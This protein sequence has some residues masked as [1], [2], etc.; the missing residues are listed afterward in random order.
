MLERAKEV[1]EA[2]IKDAESVAAEKFGIAGPISPPI[3]VPSVQEG[4]QITLEDGTKANV[5][6]PSEFL[7]ESV[8]H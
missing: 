1:V 4:M 7:N 3:D 8:N 2:G 6:I 5:K